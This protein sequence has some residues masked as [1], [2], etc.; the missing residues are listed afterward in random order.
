MRI[1][2]KRLPVDHNLF[3][4]GDDHEGTILRYDKGWNK[5]IDML[6][7][8]WGG[9]PANHNF[10]IDH[11]DF[12]EAIM[13]DDPRYDIAT[14]KDPIPMV[15]LENAVK[16]RAMIRDRLLFILEG[17]HPLKLWKFG[18]LTEILCDRLKVPYGTWSAK[19]VVQDRKGRLMYKSYHT[20][21]RKQITST[22]DDPKRRET[23]KQLI[24]KRH[25][26]FKAG[27]CALL[28]KGHTHKL[29]VC[30]PESELYMTDDGKQVQQNYT[31]ENFRHDAPFIHPDHRWY[32]NTGSFLRLFADPIERPGL[33]TKYVSG[34]GEIAEYDPIELGFAV[35]EIRD[36]KIV[37]V[38]K[39][40]L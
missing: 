11:G 40:V 31:L 5:F 3:L 23:N 36:R 12:M 21:G 1:I 14:V 15:Q 33:P 27:D 29:L 32:V 4:F 24:L 18:A 37:D 39:V 17:N 34:Y 16:N 7:S 10:A 35:A 38:K 6:H 28:A 19:L 25:L 22:A 9:L 26:K 30:K 2:T 8:P 20:H 13:I